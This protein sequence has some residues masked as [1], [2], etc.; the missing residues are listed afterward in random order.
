MDAN[1]L[2]YYF[3]VLRDW[4]LAGA[5]ILIVF[6]ML[7]LVR[8]ILIH[9]FK[10]FSESGRYKTASFVH[11]VFLGTKTWFLLW[12]AILVGSLVVRL[13]PQ[14]RGAMTTTTIILLITQAGIWVLGLIEVWIERRGGGEAGKE[15]QSSLNAL[16]FFARLVV[17]TLVVILALDNIPGV[18]VTS[19]ITSLGIGGIAIGLAVQNILSDLFSSLTITLDKPFSIGDTINVGEFTGTVEYIGLKSTRIRS[20]SG[21]QLVFSNSDLLASRIRNFK[22]M[23]RR[24]V[25][26]TLGVTYDTPAEKLQVVPQII[27]ATIEAAANT[28]F[29]RAHFKEF[30]ASALIFEVVYFVDASDYRLFMDRQQ[31]INLDIYNKFSE[32]QIQFAYPTQTIYTK[33]V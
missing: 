17:W 15:Q 18:Q 31:Q 8:G 33:N 32:N 16:Q 30:G 9:R 12:I 25:V 7:R 22:R 2:R 5:L 26:F 6:F 11:R 23:E 1:A 13:S 3:F 29:E 21:E 10:Q 19:L 27:Q 4:I 14:I 28:T 24:R 20:L